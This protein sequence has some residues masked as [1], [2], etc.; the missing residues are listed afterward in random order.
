MKTTDIPLGVCCCPA[1]KHA[2]SPRQQ[3]Q[4][5]ELIRMAEAAGKQD[6]IDCYTERLTR[7]TTAYNRDAHEQV[8]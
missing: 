1:V 6:L 5:R 8:A 3:E 7:C 2:T 4:V